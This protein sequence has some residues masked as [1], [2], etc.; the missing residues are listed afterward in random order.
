MQSQQ[1]TF[2]HLLRLRQLV[3]ELSSVTHNS[4]EDIAAN[5]VAIS[6]RAAPSALSPAQEMAAQQLIEIH[7]AIAVI[8]GG[9]TFRL[10][11]FLSGNSAVTTLVI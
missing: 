2:M 11:A 1:D 8:D 9:K 7:K 5:L 3:A 4:K 6:L 10:V